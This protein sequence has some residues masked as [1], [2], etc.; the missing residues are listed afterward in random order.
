M[1]LTIR[2]LEKSLETESGL[3]GRTEA[4]SEAL[5]AKSAREWVGCVKKEVEEVKPIT[6]KRA[7]VI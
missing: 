2:A 3:G 7:C 1:M 4:K 5:L 6:K